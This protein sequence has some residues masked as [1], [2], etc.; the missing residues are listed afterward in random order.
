MKQLTSIVA[1]LL[2]TSVSNGQKTLTID[3]NH[4]F[5]GVDSATYVNLISDN[6]IK[7]IFADT[8]E[9]RPKIST[10]E[11]TNTT[12]SG[13]DAFLE[14]HSPLHKDKP[15][16]SPDDQFGDLGGKYNDLGIVFKTRV[17]ND[18]EGVK[19]TL[20]ES[21]NKVK[22]ITDEIDD[23]G[24]RIKWTTFLWIDNSKHQKTF[25][26]II[27]EK[28][29]ELLK[30]RG[31]TDNEIS[32]EITH[33]NW[34]EKIRNKKYDKLFD[35]ITEVELNLTKSEFEYL[36]ASLTH[37]SYKQN[38]TT[39]SDNVCTIKTNLVD[40]ESAFR[41]SKIHLSLTREFESKEVII[42]DRLTVTIKGRTAV[43]NFK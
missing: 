41:V 32:K 16:F 22:A 8:R 36:V 3:L 1:F 17:T 31:F 14:F 6:F 28:S 42:S 5:L 30:S 11:W 12:I 38:G 23:N 34:K 10:A 7:D 13:R 4:I 39:L 24:K 29:K 25:R 15:I 18:I 33:E 37:F 43:Y 27:E 20:E 2:A 19:T 40:R 35:K 26:P 21:G 9:V